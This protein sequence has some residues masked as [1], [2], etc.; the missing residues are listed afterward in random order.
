MEEAKVK[1]EEKEKEGE[2]VGL[3]ELQELEQT[4]DKVQINLAAPHLSE[5]RP[6]VDQSECPASYSENSA[7]EKM[8]V[9]MAENL[10]AQYSYLYPDRKPLL[11]CP[12]N[13]LG[14][15][16]FVS[17]TL[18]R[19][20]LPYHELYDWQ[21]CA[22]FISDFLTLELLDCPTEVPKQL[23]SPTWVVQT[24]RGT[25]FDFSTLL[26]SLLLGAGYNAYCVSGYAVKEMCLLDLSNQE[27]PLL[28]PQDTAEE[29]PPEEKE[30]VNKYRVKP[31]RELK[32]TFEQRQEE[33]NQQEHH[34]LLAKQQEAKRVKEEQERPSDPLWGLRVH[35]WVL[36]MAGKRDILENFFIN[37]LSGQ[38]YPTSSAC[39][40]GI[41]SVWN[42]ENYWVNMQDCRFGCTEMTYDL[43]DVLKWE[44]MLC[45]PAVL[46]V[47]TGEE[48]EEQNDEETEEPTLFEMPQSWVAQIH[49][50]EEDM[51]SCFP[52]GSKVIR[53]RKATL[54][55]FSP[56]LL[57]DGL[58]TR[59]TTYDDLE[60]TQPNTVK[61]WYE[62]RHD[63]LQERELQKATSVT[64]ERFSSGRS[65]C[66]KTHRYVTL[67]PGTERLMEFYSN[68]RADSLVSRVETPTEMIETFQ[69]RSDFLYYRHVVYGPL[70]LAQKLGVQRRI[71][72]VVVKFHRDRSK[73]A[74][75]D[76]AELIFQISQNRIEV[77]YHLEDDRIIPNFD[78]FEKPP[79]QDDPFSDKMVSSFQVDPLGEPL[80]KLC[81]Y[82]T[83]M[84]L[85]KE[86]EKVLISIKDSE[87]EVRDILE[88]RGR[89]ESAI[90]LKISIYDMARNEKARLHVEKLKHL[91]REKQLKKE[92]EDVDVLAPFLARLGHPECLTKQ[93]AVQIHADCLDN[94]KQRLIDK[95]N[96]IQARFEKETQELLQKQQWYQKNQFNLTKQDEE[97]YLAYCSEAMFR[98][99]I[100]KLRLS[101]HKDRAP[102]KYLAL[103]KMLRHDPRLM[104]H[105]D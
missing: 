64:I 73:P 39:F 2:D 96:L 100:L 61:E 57:K 55:K 1:E 3:R 37:P 12:V 36:V 25:C 18:R 85:M 5:Q 51:E 103:D 63:E 14:V 52:G 104:Q 22:S 7:E 102:Q 56:Y 41:E 45:S 65:F 6:N 70:E 72:K 76:V 68:V 98:I 35:S 19:T 40:L 4:L 11:L 74:S 84:A 17:T 93:Q 90:M 60:W 105:R 97:A 82:Q 69:D 67:V 87:N 77:T 23:Y 26:C 50:S 79:N 46:P 101:R 48:Q 20:L 94:L 92:Y 10:H 49:I 28:K 59:L 81:L 95:A 21:G 66:L 42:H 13:E 15:Q 62:N 75:K 89:E 16:K 86:E 27:C 44:Y 80:P 83:L 33:K 58:V 88:V 38:S 47:A 99:K 53:Y 31:A 30:E 8:L 91:A 24:R 71:Q 34:A 78:I 32:S 54:E 9:S 29:K 43:H